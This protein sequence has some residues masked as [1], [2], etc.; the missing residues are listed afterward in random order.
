[1]PVG[2]TVLEGG[3]PRFHA[4]SRICGNMIVQLL[5]S[6]FSLCLPPHQ[7]PSMTLRQSSSG[8]GGRRRRRS[9]SLRRLEKRRSRKKVSD[10]WFQAYF[11]DVSWALEWC[12]ISIYNSVVLVCYGWPIRSTMIWFQCLCLHVF[13]V[14][15]VMIPANTPCLHCRAGRVWLLPV[16][17]VPLTHWSLRWGQVCN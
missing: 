17:H 6:V 9:R 16:V 13:K 8:W 15:A 7:P 5:A 2:S 12:N 1:M 14:P 4:T 10:L 11:D 3:V